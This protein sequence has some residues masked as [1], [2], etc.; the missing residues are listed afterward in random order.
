M[1]LHVCLKNHDIKDIFFPCAPERE[2]M[3]VLAGDGVLVLAQGIHSLHHSNSTPI[4]QD[5]TYKDFTTYL[6]LH[7]PCEFV[8]SGNAERSEI[9]TEWGIN[10]DLV[11]AEEYSIT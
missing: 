2:S 5:L 10:E 3:T 11:N 9:V 1:C 6:F 4:R 8:D 7:D